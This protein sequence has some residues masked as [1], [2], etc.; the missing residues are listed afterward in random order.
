M[1]MIQVQ[2]FNDL[3]SMNLKPLNR[4]E[5]QEIGGGG[6]WGFIGRMGVAALGTSIGVALIAGIVVGYI[7][8][9]VYEYYTSE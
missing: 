1:S 7:A 2:T 3:E 6:I 8:Y 4:S 9:E 5:T